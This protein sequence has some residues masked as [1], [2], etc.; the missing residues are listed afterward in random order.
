MMQLVG[1]G[2]LCEKEYSDGRREC[3]AE[4]TA[5]NPDMLDGEGLAG[6]GVCPGGKETTRL[7]Y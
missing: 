7:D 2:H 3:Y 6:Q 1:N 4:K 5:D